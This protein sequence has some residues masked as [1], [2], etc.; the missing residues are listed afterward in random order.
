MGDRQP[1]AKNFL[2]RRK[3]MKKLSE[4][5]KECCE[6]GIP[7]LE[8][9]KVSKEDLIRKLANY[10]I[11]HNPNG[12]SALEQVC[13][14]LARDITELSEKEREEV[15][16]SDRFACGEKKNGI[17][18]ILH[19]RPEGN[20]FT[21]RNR[22]SDTYL[23]NELTDNVPHLCSLDLGQWKGS[24]FDGEL[25]LP[26]SFVKLDSM[27]N[28]LEATSALLHCSP[29]KAKEF[30]ETA[31]NKIHYHIFD[32]LKAEG[33]DLRPLSFKHR[34]E[35]LNEFKSYIDSL[36]GNQ[37][38]EFEDLIFKDKEQYFREVIKAGG[39]GIVLKD[40]EA[41]YFPGARSQS[42]L[43]LKRSNTVDA[44][45]I[46]YDRGKEWDKKGLIGSIELGVFDECGDLRSIGRVSSLSLQKR[47]DMTEVVE[48]IPTLRKQYLGTVVECRFQ[49]LNKNLRGRHLQILTFREGQ[50]AKPT[51]E[52]YLNLSRQKEN[53]KRVGIAI[54]DH[55]NERLLQ[56]GNIKN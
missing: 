27:A 34:L 49:E 36:E 19:I 11:E 22:C 41:P 4:L 9:P 28:A 39:E 17:R 16:K 5:I 37:F 56:I 55:V 50:N 23:L 38:I 26:D 40:L 42:W 43:K 46:G 29:E 21:S 14:Q 31:G 18:G 44:I 12:P 52:C 33:K 7:I 6:K 1:E 53:L 32:V 10:H 35:Y 25:Y 45:V 2:D 15:L 3:A 8:G 48:G 54:P 13:P 47:S 51:S 30:Q 24:I 20:C